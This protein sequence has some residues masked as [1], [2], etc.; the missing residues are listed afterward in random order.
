MS[1]SD[2]L[3]P[4]PTL[5]GMMM[6]CNDL[7]STLTAAATSSPNPLTPPRNKPQRPASTW[8]SEADTYSA[9]AASTVVDAPALIA[10]RTGT[11]SESQTAASPQSHHHHHPKP[12]TPTR[13]PSPKPTR[14]TTGTKLLASRSKDSSSK[15]RKQS[16]SDETTEDFIQVTHPSPGGSSASGAGG[17]SPENSPPQSHHRGRLGHIVSIS[18]IKRSLSQS[19]LRLPR[20]P[21]RIK[22]AMSRLS[23]GW[24]LH[25]GEREGEREREKGRGERDGDLKGERVVEGEVIGEVLGEEKEEVQVVGKEGRDLKV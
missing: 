6:S 12:R 7:P 17:R 25:F 18:G 15:S 16:S 19:D 2:A 23:K 4:A 20:R 13:S 10:S 22:S 14:A 1:S 5:M 24:Q 8:H 21:S 9:S 11:Q 3:D